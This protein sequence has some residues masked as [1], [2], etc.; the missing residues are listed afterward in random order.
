MSF[1]ELRK[2]FRKKLM[3]G[4][5]TLVLDATLTPEELV[6]LEELAKSES[7]DPNDLAALVLKEIQMKTRQTDISTE[8]H[9]ANRED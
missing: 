2:V 5:A 4:G 1:P 8:V 3:T 9:S 7:S 6:Q